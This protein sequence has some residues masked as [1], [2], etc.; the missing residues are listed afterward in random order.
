M[1]GPLEMVEV[2][3]HIL[4]CAHGVCEIQIVQKG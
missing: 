4:I 1:R 3:M 2:F